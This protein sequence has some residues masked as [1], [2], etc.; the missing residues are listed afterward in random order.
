MMKRTLSEDPR[1]VIAIPLA[2]PMI[3]WRTVGALLE[4]EKPSESDLMV[5]QGALVDRARNYLVE[6]MLGHSMEPTHLLFL[7][8][9]ILV[10]PDTL[11]KLLA[12]QKLIVSALYRKRLPPYEPMAFRKERKRFRPV[13]LK[14]RALQ[15]VDVV[16]SGCLLI[17]RDVLESIRPP[18]FTSD[19]RREGHL[20][21][22][23]SFCEKAKKAGFDIYV[24][25]A[26]PV[27]HME[28]IGIG[29]DT[30]QGVAFIPLG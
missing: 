30:K 23:F 10:Q 20:S 6:K 28:V 25:L 14:G 12:H 13:S 9:D 22:D 24:D 5:F 17:R 21:E 29:T 15:S 19:W 4:M 2:G 1:I 7:D 18:W 3:Y 11:V 27:A 16:G 8:A 26:S